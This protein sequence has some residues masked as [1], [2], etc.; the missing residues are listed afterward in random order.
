MKQAAG[1]AVKALS[2]QLK[3]EFSQACAF[4]RRAHAADVQWMDSRRTLV[5][6]FEDF[7]SEYA[8]GVSGASV[9]L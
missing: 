8:Y 4:S 5:E 6:Q 2:K 1:V 3:N 7:F 9:P